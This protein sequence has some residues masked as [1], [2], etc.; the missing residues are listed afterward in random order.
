MKLGSIL[1]GASMI[2][3]SATFAQDDNRECKRMRFI[4][5]EAMRVENYK[6]ATEYF[7]KAEVTCGPDFLKNDNGEDIGSANYDRL[8]GSLIRVINVE[9][10]ADA[11]K[12]YADT[13]CAIWDRMDE[14]SLYDNK[15]DMYRGNFELQK[16]TPGYLKADKYFTRGIAAHANGGTPVQ[17]MYIPLHYYNTFTL[18][19]MEQDAEN[20]NVIKKR[21]INDYFDL[22]KLITKS[23]FSLRAQEGITVYFNSAV[24]TCDDLTP[25]IAGFI[26]DLSEDVEAAKNSLMSLIDLMETK[27]CEDTQEY[28]DLINA[29][30]ERDPESLKALEMKAKILEKEN[31]YREANVIYEKLIA[32]PEITDERKAELKYK[33]VDNLFKMRSYN[34]AYSKAMNI[35]GKFRGKAMSIAGQCVGQLANECGVSTFDRNCNFI[36]AVQLLEQSGGAAGASLITSYKAEFPTARDCFGEGNPASVTLE[37]WGV[38]VK[39]CN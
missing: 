17:E 19:L 8:T 21:M 5:N 6:E 14:Q 10:D 36:Y 34:A 22:S 1:L 9:T 35:Q 24:Q 26:A 32:S 30:L 11:K 28:M 12:L 33:I 3:A 25:E 16:S 29:Y 38:T 20:K 2:L 7:I 13:L 27:R 15:N 23:N 39:P 18:F 31:K 37:C 4:A